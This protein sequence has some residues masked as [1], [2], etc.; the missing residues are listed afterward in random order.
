MV[1][2]VGVVGAGTM[3]VGVSLAFAR[4][5]RAVVLVDVNPD[6]LRSARGRIRH[7]ARFAGL[8]DRSGQAPVGDEVL[9]LIRFTTDAA[10]LAEV[11][12][13]VENVTEDWQVKRALYRRLDEVC[14]ADCVLAVNTS[15]IP[16]TKLAGE[17]SRP[18]RVIGN[19]FMNPAH[20]MPLVEVIRGVHTSD[21]T[22][23]AAQALLAG[24]GKDSLVVRDSPGFVTNRVLM[25]T[26]NEAVFLLQEG[27]STAPE[28]D[29]L[30]RQCFG[31]RM[32]PLET[33][34]LIGLDTILYSLE[35][36][37]DEFGDPKYRPCPLL[38]RHVEAGWLGRKTG[39]GF[40]DH[41][42]LVDNGG[43]TL[44]REAR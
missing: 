5:K 16:I 3:G 18:D 10:E 38:R 35:V 12:Y 2:P 15:A 17:S 19:H 39:R 34:D 41:A 9:D 14:A 30:F 27:V 7:E 22:V 26:I 6:A 40:H 25:L 31:H 20:L 43:P 42:E 33:A 29:R 1:A 23:A 13:L 36:L 24:I 32:G 37:V 8:V 4:S 28:I 21:A 44:S 11:D